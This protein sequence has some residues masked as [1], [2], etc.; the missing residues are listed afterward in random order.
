MKTAHQLRRLVDVA[1]VAALV[2]LAA[3]TWAIVDPRPVPVFVAM[4]AGQVIGTFSLFLFLVT[5]VAGVTRPGEIQEDPATLAAHRIRR[6]W[7]RSLR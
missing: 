5:L 3:M 6:R 7:R 2:G 1:C 4:S